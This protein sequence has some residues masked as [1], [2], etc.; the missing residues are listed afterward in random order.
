VPTVAEIDHHLPQT[1]CT[2]CG[3]PNCRAYATALV[4]QE[5]DI[6]RC[7]PGGTTTLSA[8]AQYFPRPAVELAGDCKPHSGRK[9]AAII[10]AQCIGCTICLACCPVDAIL[11]A[12][13]QMHSVLSEDCTGCELC[14]PACPVDCITMVEPI[15]D[16]QG[17][18]WFEF[19]DEE[20]ARFRR[21][22]NRHQNRRIAKRHPGEVRITSAETIKQQI[23]GAVNRER[24][25]RWRQ[26]NRSAALSN[27]RDTIE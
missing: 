26:S 1:Q 17:E 11:G 5:T 14:I 15:A 19:L 9:V 23:H 3:Y 24:T 4:N 22:A 27:R 7:P 8:L 12:S 21:L 25:R 16:V 6:N 20:I 13:K 10:E 18:T 2:K